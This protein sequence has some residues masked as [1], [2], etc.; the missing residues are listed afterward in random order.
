MMKKA[1]CFILCTVLLLC[2]AA[3]G[4]KDDQINPETN[5][6]A[7]AKPGTDSVAEDAFVT[8]GVAL[9]IGGTIQDG[10]LAPL[11]NPTDVQSAPSCHY[12][13]NDTIYIYDGLTVY[14]YS[15][16]DDEVV[17]LIEITNESYAAYKNTKIGMNVDEIKS[18]LG[19]P[20]DETAI[21]VIYDISDD[22]TLRFSVS[23][24]TVTMIE[25][26]ERI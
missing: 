2:L 3:C 13:G 12:D 24:S 26:E 7:T 9:S 18:V 17:Y 22:T 23:D 10:D 4:G 19:E 11:G 5:S 15:D 25:Y 14:T 1:M 20:A 16:K 8:D 21:A 6:N